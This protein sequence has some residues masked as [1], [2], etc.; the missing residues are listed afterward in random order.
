MTTTEIITLFELVV[1]DVTELSTSEETALV[2]R[3]YNRI[4][5]GHVWEFLKTNATGSILS[6]ADGYYI[7]LPDNFAFF[8]E[9][10]QYTDNSIGVNNNASPKVVFV[11]TNYQRYQIVN[12]SDR[13]QYR[14]KDGYCYL[15]LAN[16]KIR[17]TYTPVAFT[18]DFDYCKVPATLT[19]ATSP[20]FP[21]RFHEM[22]AYFMATENDVLQLSPKATSYKDD[23]T[24][25]ARNYLLDMKHWNSMLIL[26]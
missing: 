18:Y 23:N 26:N 16:S 9:N 1:D 5:N 8:V 25:I 2:N 3:I 17:F 11:G 24:V 4:C 22:I 14:N 10:N 15:D 20:V 6:D 13:R 21:A 19:A 7:T 12:Y